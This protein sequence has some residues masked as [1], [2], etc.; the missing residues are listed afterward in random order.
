MR[1]VKRGKGG[2]RE[3]GREGGSEGGWEGGREGGGR[4][5]GKGRREEGIKKQYTNLSMASAGHMALQQCHVAMH[6]MAIRHT[7]TLTVRRGV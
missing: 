3:G 2:E 7:R 4:G 6:K 1:G 5:R